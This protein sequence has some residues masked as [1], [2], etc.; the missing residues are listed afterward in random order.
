VLTYKNISYTAFRDMHIRDT[1]I[2][3]DET[4]WG[5]AAAAKTATRRNVFTI[6]I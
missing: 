6:V 3:T 2:A 4:V 1:A 5:I